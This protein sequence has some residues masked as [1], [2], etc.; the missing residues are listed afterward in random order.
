MT[1]FYLFNEQGVCCGTTT[2]EIY[3]SEWADANEGYYCC[4]QPLT[5]QGQIAQIQIPHFVQFAYCIL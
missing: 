4:D 3:A 2:D 1:V 5:S